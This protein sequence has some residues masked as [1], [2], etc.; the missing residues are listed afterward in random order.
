MVARIT[1]ARNRLSSR[2]VAARSVVIAMALVVGACGA[3][4]PRLSRFARELPRAQESSALD[5]PTRALLGRSLGDHPT[6]ERVH[7]RLDFLALAPE[8]LS[9]DESRALLESTLDWIDWARRGDVPDWVEISVAERPT[10][11]GDAALDLVAELGTPTPDPTPTAFERVGSAIR[12]TRRLLAR[13]AP[14]SVIV[15][16]RA[17]MASLHGAS[18]E[19]DAFGEEGAVAAA[20]QELDDRVAHAL[21]GPTVERTFYRAGVACHVSTLD[22]GSRLTRDDGEPFASSCWA[23]GGDSE[24]ACPEAAVDL[25][26]DAERVV[27]VLVGGA[28]QAER[29]VVVWRDDAWRVVSVELAWT[30]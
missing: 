2:V 12:G 13:S 19:C 5:E 8:R 16:W 22:G 28:L 4:A 25:P 23:R 7:A 21:N 14:P 20:L 6:R 15:A 24:H 9:A 26:P 29:V 3:S 10:S 27:V 17:A 30:T 18:D 1:R 11:T